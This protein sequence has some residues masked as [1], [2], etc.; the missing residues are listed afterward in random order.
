MTDLSQKSYGNKCRLGKLNQHVTR[1][2][3]PYFT[4]MSDLFSLSCNLP[5][6]RDQIWWL[7]PFFVL[8]GTL[9]YFSIVR[10]ENCVAY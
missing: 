9:S 3:L 8:E 7:Y 5:A 6:D 1:A 10:L 2:P 4:N